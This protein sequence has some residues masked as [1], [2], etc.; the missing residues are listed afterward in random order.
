MTAYAVATLRNLDMNHEIEDY[1]RR[2]DA[3]LDDH[4]GRFLV[5]GQTAEEIEGQWHGVL[6][7]LEFPDMARLKA[8]YASPGYQAILGHRTRNSEGEV[9]FVAGVPEGYRAAQFADRMFG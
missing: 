8:W 6:I 9:A 7:L 2:I 5:H 1:L 4:G 3:T